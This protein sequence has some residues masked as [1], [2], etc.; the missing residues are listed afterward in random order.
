M[1]KTFHYSV[2]VG[3]SRY[4]EQTDEDFCDTVDYDYEVDTSSI[5]AALARIITSDYFG[6]IAEV[7]NNKELSAAIT[8]AI[9]SFIWDN[10]LEDDLADV[11]EDDLKDYFE[12]EAIESFR[13]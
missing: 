2:E 6:K 13:G 5:R 11:Y 3:I 9:L 8:N 1:S 4:S 10:D 12:E 7:K